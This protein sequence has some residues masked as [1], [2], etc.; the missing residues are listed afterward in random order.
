MDASKGLGSV[1]G[2][3]ELYVLPDT[4]DKRYTPE[5]EAVARTDE[6]SKDPKDKEIRELNE[7][8][9]ALKAKS[10]AIK[11][12]AIKAYGMATFSV[13]AYGLA[14]AAVFGA[15]PV[16]GVGLLVVGALGTIVG[17]RYY[18]KI[19]EIGNTIS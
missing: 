19:H 12:N 1:D 11:S 2:A 3:K 15:A 7:K 18:N 9:E 14:M 6:F 5:S 13:A 16:L 17:N 10:K 4:M 8:L